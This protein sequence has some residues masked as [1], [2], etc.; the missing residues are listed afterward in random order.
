VKRL[1]AALAIAGGTLGI[2]GA[3]TP[4]A[5]AQI[6]CIGIWV[7]VFGNQIIAQRICL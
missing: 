7:T 4:P 5:N 6:P 2:F 1:I 3:Y